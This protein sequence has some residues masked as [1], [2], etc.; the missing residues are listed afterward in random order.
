MSSATAS[1]ATSVALLEDTI[2]RNLAATVRRF[3]DSDALI[4]PFQDVRLTYAAL[5]REVDNVARA[6]L[7]A[8]LEKGDRVGIWSPNNAE[9]VLVQYA[10]AEVGVILVNINP[11]YRTHEVKYALEQSGCRL[12][13]SA[14]DFKTSDYRGMIDEIRSDL[15]GLERVVFLATD[16]WHEF[17]AAGEGVGDDD[18]EAARRPSTATTRSTSSTRA[19]RPGSRRARRSVTATSSTTASS[20]AKAAGTQKPIACASPCPSITASAWCSGTSRARRTAPR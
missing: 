3:G 20:S 17:I 15:P 18:L 14:T 1:G 4:V 16:D 12:L 13:I 5:A 6:L 10:T 9:W 7:A 19:A 8:G 11:A 2:G